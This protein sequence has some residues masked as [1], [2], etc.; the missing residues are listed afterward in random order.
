MTYNNC[1]DT[2]FRFLN[3]IRNVHRSQLF[4]VSPENSSSEERYSKIFQDLSKV[5][6]FSVKLLES[7]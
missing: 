7:I 6:S 4:K 3:D 1:F 2:H 5:L